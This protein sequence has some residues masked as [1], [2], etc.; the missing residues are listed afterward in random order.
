MMKSFFPATLLSLLAVCVSAPIPAQDD[1]ADH[2]KH[3][4]LTASVNTSGER[5]THE[6]DALRLL[7]ACMPRH[8]PSTCDWKKLKERN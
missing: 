6:P 3:M 1:A 7:P 2:S 5:V 8:K 4:Q